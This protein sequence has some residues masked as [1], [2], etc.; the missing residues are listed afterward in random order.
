[1]GEFLKY[2]TDVGDKTQAREDNMYSQNEIAYKIFKWRWDRYPYH[3][4][5]FKQWDYKLAGY[6]I[7]ES[8]TL[9]E[10]NSWLRR[11]YG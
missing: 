2:L 1:M 11:N 10:L 5:Y 9:I 6:F 3:S 7:E 4:D 8:R